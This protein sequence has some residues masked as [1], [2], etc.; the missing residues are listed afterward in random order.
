[1]YYYYLVV[2]LLF[3][4]FMIILSAKRRE[5][6]TYGYEAVAIIFFVECCGNAMILIFSFTWGGLLDMGAGGGGDLGGSGPQTSDNSTP[7]YCNHF[8][9]IR[10]FR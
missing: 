4:I 1:M 9:K 2:L 8:G 10:I 6:D 3:H 7:D 5:R